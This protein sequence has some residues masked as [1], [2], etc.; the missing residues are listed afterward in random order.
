[1]P[2]SKAKSRLRSYVSE[3]AKFKTRQNAARASGSRSGTTKQDRVLILLRSQDG[4]TIAAIMKLT[5]WRP[6]S[7]RGFFA[8]V[9]R[10]VQAALARLDRILSPAD[11]RIVLNATRTPRKV[12]WPEWWSEHP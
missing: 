2:R 7:V 1:M 6:H 11:Q 4:A 5:G 8:G 12:R 9:V 10:L 3:R